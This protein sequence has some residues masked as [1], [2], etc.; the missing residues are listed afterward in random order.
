MASEP[1]LDRDGLLAPYSLALMIAKPGKP[2]NIRDDLVLPAAAE[3]LETVLHQSA[4]TI[5]SI[6]PL[7][8]R[9]VQGGIDAMARRLKIRH[10]VS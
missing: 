1:K 6:I 2:H 10:A 8:R 7:G 4:C 9:T 5:V 3:I